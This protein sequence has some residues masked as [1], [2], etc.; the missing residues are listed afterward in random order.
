MLLS[1]RSLDKEI[2]EN[3]YFIFDVKNPELIFSIKNHIE[4]ELK[5]I[6]KEKNITLE[7][8]HTYFDND[9]IHYENQ[10]VMTEF[11]R[12]KKFHEIIIKDNLQIFKSILGLDLDLQTEPYLRMARP[13]KIN[14]NIG[15]HRDTYYGTAADELSVFIPFVELNNEAAL[16]VYPKSHI[17]PDSHFPTEQTVNE[18]V[19]KGSKKNQIGFLYAPKKITKDISEYMNPIS[20]KPGQILVFMLSIVHGSIVNNS[21]S[22]RW[23]TDVRVK[24][25]FYDLNSTMKE[26]YYMELNRSQP[27]KASQI[28]I[29]N[30]EK[31]VSSL[32]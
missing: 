4:Q 21:N 17:L 10:Y 6:T 14:D 9:D 8:Y 2:F 7:K 3:G 27:Y 18:N 26:N 25:H 16:S 1:K 19:T 30:N 12:S 23:S 15:Y 31:S 29:K 11:F 32:L 13:N 5:K 22:T 20:L 24:N 28:Y